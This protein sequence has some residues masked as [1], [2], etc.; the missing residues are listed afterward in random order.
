MI[1]EI[2]KDIPTYEGLYKC[3]N[4]GNILSLGNNKSKKDKILKPHF[5]N[6]YQIGLTKDGIRKQY[7]IHQLVAITFLNHEIDNWK[8]V[9]NHINGIKT[10]NFVENL[11]IISNREN[12]SKGYEKTNTSSKYTGVS[13]YNRTSK[14]ISTI[15][16]SNKNKKIGLGYF[17]CELKAAYVYNMYLKNCST[18]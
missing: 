14:W 9:V 12:I 16:D 6:Y 1:N 8:I 15:W 2:W 10:D 13:F 4:F 18:K 7:Y 5:K 3:S 11:E 17:K